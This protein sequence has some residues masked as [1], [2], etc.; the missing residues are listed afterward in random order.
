MFG[1]GRLA[2]TK[3]FFRED[4]GEVVSAYFDGE[5][6]FVARLTKKFETVELDAYDLDKDLKIEQIAERIS[7]LCIKRGWKTSAVGFCLREQDAH[8]LR[9]EVDNI[10]EKEIPAMV[11]SW[12][13][14]QAG[15]D[16]IFSS[17]KVGEEVWVEAL[18]RA[19]Y[20]EICAAFKKFNLN[21]RA[22][23]VMPA[24]E[25]K[26]IHPFERTEFITEVVR[27]RKAPNLLSTSSSVWNWKKISQVAAGIFLIGLPICSAKLFIDYSAASNKLDAAKIAVDEIS[28]DVALKQ[29]LD[30]DIA[31]LHRLNTL[32]A[33]VNAPQNFNLLINLGKIADK[34]IR[35][36][37]IRLD[38]NSLELEGIA[39]K[40]DAVKNYLARVKEFVIKSTRLESS[41]ENDDG[42]IIFTMRAAF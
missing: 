24:D 21:L 31:E 8:I 12:A 34:N 1:E 3:K 2:R 5:K 28:T 4:T 18:P 14:A 29:K 41:F 26:K 35:M 17:V 32:A 27:E 6:I 13:T 38:G 19:R 25:L 15:A 11:K 30:A 16:A 33:Q 20:K 40:P 23:S 22:L 36:K 39:T 42:E 9:T 10:P 7:L 37:K